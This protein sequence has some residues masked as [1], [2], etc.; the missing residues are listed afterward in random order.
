[1][2]DA[3]KIP[4]IHSGVPDCTS[5]IVSYHSDYPE[6]VGIHGT[7][8][9]ARKLDTVVFITARHCL[10]NNNQADIADLASRL[11]IPYVRSGMKLARDD[12]VEFSDVYSF[13]HSNPEIPGE[14]VD[15]VILRANVATG[16]K[17]HKKLMARA[18]KLPPAGNWFDEFTRNALVQEALLNGGKIPLLVIGYPLDQTATEVT[19]DKVIQVQ[20]VI[21]AGYLQPGFYPHT[22]GM[23]N[24]VWE[25]NLN[26]FSGSPVFI[27]FRNRK[28]TPQQALVGMIVA[29][30]NMQAQFIRISQ[31]ALSQFDPPLWQ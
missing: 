12:Y 17:Q 7:G 11:L 27:Q 10:T 23:N 5:P 13:H 15:L 26:G 29:G 16:S 1:M 30:G 4:F 31:I 3:S 14:Y 24:I 19:P 9:F 2:S 28:G 18:V 25:H 20:K 21:T 8:F 22:M 6:Y